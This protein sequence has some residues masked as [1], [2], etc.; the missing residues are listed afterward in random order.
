MN[1]ISERADH[2]TL[3]IKFEDLVQLYQ[4]AGCRCA[5]T[6][7]ILNTSIINDPNTKSIFPAPPDYFKLSVDRIDSTLGY[8]VGI[9]AA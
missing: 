9:I 8:M 7:H 3:N 4:N 1:S 2:I 5:L 6:G